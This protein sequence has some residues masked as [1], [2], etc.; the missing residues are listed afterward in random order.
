MVA[1]LWLDGSSAIRM[2]FAD[3]FLRPE[4]EIANGLAK[5]QPRSPEGGAQRPAAK[6]GRPILLL[7]W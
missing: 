6:T 5:S 2:R 4:F 7:S 1:R 3:G